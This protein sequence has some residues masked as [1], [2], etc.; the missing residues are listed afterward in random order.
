M[1]KTPLTAL[2]IAELSLQAGIPDGVFN[3]VVTTEAQKAGE[4]LTQHE[5]VNKFTFTGSTRVGKL[6]MAQAA[7]TVKRVSMELGG[8]A[9]PYRLC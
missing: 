7:T 3:V 4:L 6:L 5:K 2:A 1:L 9:P 8:N